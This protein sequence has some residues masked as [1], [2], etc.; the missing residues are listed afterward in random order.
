MEERDGTSKAESEGGQ[1]QAM[2]DG[3]LEM[4]QEALGERYDLMGERREPREYLGQDDDGD[5]EEEE[6]DEEG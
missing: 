4:Q 5:R 1:E 3:S 2:S 6:S